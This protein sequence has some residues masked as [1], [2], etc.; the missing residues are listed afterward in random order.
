VQYRI[1]AIDASADRRTALTDEYT[2]AVTGHPEWPLHLTPEDPAL[3]SGPAHGAGAPDCWSVSLYPEA[4]PAFELH[5]EAAAPATLS[6]RAFDCTELET[7][8]LRFWHYLRAG[9]DE[10]A[11]V[12]RLL[13]SA[14]GGRTFAHI[15]WTSGRGR[16]GL[17]EE[18][19][20]EVPAVRVLA[21]VQRAM[22]RFEF[23]GR[24]YWR[25]RDIDVRGSRVPQTAP[26]QNLVIAVAPPGIRLCWKPMPDA[27][28]MR[29]SR[30]RR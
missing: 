12:A 15:L 13:A 24:W 9:E 14:D 16:G 6:T 20:V 10:T 3:S 17:L 5:A 26:V 28:R 2:I 4:A 8:S 27:Y 18:G 22:L 30:G 19:I 11:P 1:R 29:C 7:V 25:L 23:T 21:G